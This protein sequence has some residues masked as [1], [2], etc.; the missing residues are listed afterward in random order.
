MIKEDFRALTGEDP[1]DIFGS[2]W[3]NEIDYFL[4]NGV[5]EAEEEELLKE[6]DELLRKY[7][8]ND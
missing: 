6:T 1:E 3:Q 2:G 8:N 5:E 4:N 7:K